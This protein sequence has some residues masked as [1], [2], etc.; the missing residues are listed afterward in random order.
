M[1]EHNDLG[2]SG[3]RI[4]LDFLREKGYRIKATNW[5]FG[6]MEVDIIAEHHDDLVMV[7]VKARSTTYYGHPMDFVDKRKQRYLVKAANAFVE[8]N[9]I[10]KNVRFDVVAVVFK[11]KL[12]VLHLEEAFHP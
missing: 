7:E 3:E 4:A 8:K 1:A 6:K 9:Q 11:P 5:R 12:E 10:D 2:Q